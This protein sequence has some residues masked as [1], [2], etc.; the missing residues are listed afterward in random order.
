MKHIDRIHKIALSLIALPFVAK[1][2]SLLFFS[3]LHAN[4]AIV[5]FFSVGIYFAYV[6]WLGFLKLN[7]KE[8]NDKFVGAA[9]F[10]VLLDILTY[11][12]FK[13]WV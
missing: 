1:L 10:L 2:I 7:E 3:E 11:Y 12:I 8:N 5:E 6:G 13:G 4:L 9:T